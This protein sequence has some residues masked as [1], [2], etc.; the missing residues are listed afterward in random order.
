ML[1]EIAAAWRQAKYPVVFTGAGM[2]TESGLPDFRS[3]QGLW[4]SRPEALATMAALRREPAEFYFFYQWRIARLWATA[5][6][7]GH[8]ALA[9][10]ADKGFVRRLITQNVD[11]FHQWAG[12]AAVELH[13]TLRTVSCL[14]CRAEY[15]SR[16]LLPAREYWEEE[17]RAG[18]YAPGPE[19]RCAACGGGLRPDVVLFGESL[20]EGPWAEAAAASHEADFFLVV[21]SSLA[22]GPANLCPEFALDG[23]ARLA[24][25]NAEATHLDGRAAWLVRDKAAGTL[26]A[27]AGRIIG[28]GC[29]NNRP[30]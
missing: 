25:I 26:A 18:R 2:S 27:L 8:E 1:D 13:G 5:P 4:K 28:C 20:P 19:C 10:L 22:V 17:Y 23:G 15:D 30:S 3:A 7:P 21:G 11:G 29:G 16:T 12:S 9:A 6:N 24:I 14:A